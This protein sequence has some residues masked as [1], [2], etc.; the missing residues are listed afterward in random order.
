VIPSLLRSEKMGGA[1]KVVG[2]LWGDESTAI[3]G[4]IGRAP[5][6]IPVDVVLDDVRGRHA[7]HYEVIHEDTS[8]A[9]FLTTCV[10]ES[11][12]AHSSPPRDHTV[13]H[14]IEID[15]GHLGT[16]VSSNLTS[17]RWVA[18]VI[19]DVR[20]PVETLLNAPLP[21]RAKVRSV[22][23]EIDIQ[24]RARSA[25]IYHAS[26]PKKIYKP[27]ET[28]TATV[29]WSH[30]RKEPMYTYGSYSLRL[31]DDLPDGDYELTLCSVAG[32]LS[33]LKTEKPHLFRVQTLSEALA[34]FNLMGGFTGDRLYMRLGLK[35]GGLSYKQL[36]MPDLPASRRKIL[37]DSKLTGDLSAYSEALVVEHKTDF[38]VDGRQ[39][40][41]LQVKRHPDP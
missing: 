27:G 28:V 29:R 26:L 7:Y 24:D 14:K 33:A 4:T 1:L 2:T 34:A 10:L 16:C 8:T 35:R 41:P 11:V 9:Y 17:Q 19:A 21:V 13:R 18:D 30:Y 5:A 12:Y 20:Y 40:L 25:Q 31:P 38:M 36:E 32:H 23:V 6:M 39:T 15:F 37:S 3:S 22:R